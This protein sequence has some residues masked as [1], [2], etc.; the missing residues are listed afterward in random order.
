[1][2][3]FHTDPGLQAT[4]PPAAPAGHAGAGAEIR[5]RLFLS[6]ARRLR[7]HSDPVLGLCLRRPACPW[8]H[9]GAQNARRHPLRRGARR[10]PPWGPR[11][12]PGPRR[13]AGL[14]SAAMLVGGACAPRPYRPVAAEHAEVDVARSRCRPEPSA[15]S[16]VRRL[17]VDEIDDP[18]AITEASAGPDLS[19]TTRRA[20]NGVLSRCRLAVYL[21]T[22]R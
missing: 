9:E 1:M 18:L 12:A 4:A 10:R 15:R 21:R 17:W 2:V 20:P 7:R 14:D 22:T 19:T 3:I 5:G 11:A 16:P 13:A 6:T 8:P